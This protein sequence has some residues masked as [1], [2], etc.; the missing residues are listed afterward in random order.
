MVPNGY[1]SDR[2]GPYSQKNAGLKG[3]I[4]HDSFLND[5][6]QTSLI[7][8]P[9]QPLDSIVATYEYCREN[10]KLAKIPVISVRSPSIVYNLR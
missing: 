7:T 2:P 3:L 5:L 6:I 10:G 1:T 4:D 8:D 9:P